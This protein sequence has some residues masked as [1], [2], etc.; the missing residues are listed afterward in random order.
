M[1]TSPAVP[2]P[3]V[4]PPG[5]ESPW[6][7]EQ[8]ERSLAPCIHLSQCH[9]HPRGQML[10]PSPKEPQVPSLAALPT[11]PSPH[12]PAV[13]FLGLHSISPAHPPAT[14]GREWMQQGLRQDGGIEGLEFPSSYKS[15]QITTN[16]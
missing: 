15:P 1:P 7:P 2:L 9:C 4:L 5:L 12:Q 13:P 10:T 8:Q 6:F 11:R 3:A 14:V 16:Y